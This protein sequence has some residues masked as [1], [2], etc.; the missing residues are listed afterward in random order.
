MCFAA[1]CRTL[2]I[3]FW[4]LIFKSADA[5]TST[6][7]AS[8]CLSRFHT[9]CDGHHRTEVHHTGPRLPGAL[10]T[11]GPDVTGTPGL[12]L[13]ISRDVSLNQSPY[14]D[15]SSQPTPFRQPQGLLFWML[16]NVKREGGLTCPLSI[17]GGRLER[18]AGSLHFKS[19]S[20]RLKPW[21]KSPIS[22]RNNHGSFMADGATL[23]STR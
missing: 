12:H 3:C 10:L 23:S 16:W 11:D 8:H 22:M 13:M 1:V 20:P 7:A 17:P 15:R 2:T 18:D 5:Q 19:F 6:V 4:N 9:V 14:A 21:M